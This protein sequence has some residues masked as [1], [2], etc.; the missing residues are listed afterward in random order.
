MYIL[1]AG[2]VAHFL[3]VGILDR[4][5]CTVGVRNP[6]P[7]ENG[8]VMPTLYLR[9][10]LVPA[11]WA[12]DGSVLSETDAGSGWVGLASSSTTWRQSGTREH[13]TAQN[14]TARQETVL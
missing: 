5:T 10:G 1:L 13:R 12:G 3:E 7:G 9:V 6:N 14:G 8:A 11:R 4:R 2:L